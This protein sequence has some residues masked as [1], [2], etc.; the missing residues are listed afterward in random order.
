MERTADYS[1]NILL[2]R[3]YKEG[4]KE[5][6]E[7]LT[8]NNLKL[9]RSIALRFTGRGYE[10]EDLIETGIIGL[11][12]A[13]DGFDE[14]LGYSFSTYAFPL[15]TGEIK[16]FLRDDGPI[17]ISRKAKTNALTVMKAKDSFINKNHREPKLS[18][19]SCITGLSTEEITEALDISRPIM[20]LQDK[21][22]DSDGDLT[23]SDTIAD[24]DI[25]ENI[26]ERIALKQAI[27]SL[28]QDEQRI[29]S[30]RYFRNLTQTKVSE[31]L[32]VSQVTISRSEK[33]IINKLR[34][35]IL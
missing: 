18:E 35:E 11:L 20:S 17:K 26:T 4:D 30:L 2:L 5:A 12:K 3:Q 16:R 31:L 1:E 15:I 32:G 33:K 10:L 25:I 28:S 24:K 9:V 7:K 21:I 8:Q 34:Q 13:L 29:I 6:L 22:S 27:S 19:L 23:I 14:S